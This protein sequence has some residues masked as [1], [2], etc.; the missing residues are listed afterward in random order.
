MALTLDDRPVHRLSVD[1][2]MRMLHSGVLTEDSRVELLEGVLVE[3]SPKSPEHEW[4]IQQVNR[5]LVPLYAHGLS[6]GIG[7][8]LVMPDGISMP[9]PDLSVIAEMR[10]DAHPASA[11]L[12]VEVSVTS[13]RVDRGTKAAL[14]ATAGVPEYWIV[15]VEHQRVEVRREPTDGEYRSVATFGTDD[16]IAPLALDLPPLALSTIF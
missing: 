11:M 2:V 3:V 14:Y 15:D 12:V 6:V 4:V 10:R 9:E 5:W 8:P 13:L 16:E 1:D 7:L